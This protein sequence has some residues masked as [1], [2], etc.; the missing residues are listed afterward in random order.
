M[1]RSFWNIAKGIKSHATGENEEVFSHEQLILAEETAETLR[2]VV[3]AMSMQMRFASVRT[4]KFPI[5]AMIK[6][7][8]NVVQS[9][10]ECIKTTHYILEARGGGVEAY[11]SRPFMIKS[12]KA[13]PV[14]PIDFSKFEIDPKIKK[15]VEDALSWMRSAGVFSNLTK[16]YS[17]IDAFLPTLEKEM[18]S[19]SK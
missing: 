13:K 6:S 9:I 7:I 1:L 11:T 8:H 4:E 10:E 14:D 16:V 18:E 17:K 15:T 3:E 5:D 2:H 12:Y 19:F